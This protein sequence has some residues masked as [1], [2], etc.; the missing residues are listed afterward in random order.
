MSNKKG[1]S[2]NRA[3]LTTILDLI[4]VALGECVDIEG[5]EEGVA[6]IEGIKSKI[7]GVLSPTDADVDPKED[8]LSPFD[9]DT[10]ILH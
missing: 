10:D 4:D 6:H 2:L 5:I 1:V 9:P 3:E 7:E 8:I